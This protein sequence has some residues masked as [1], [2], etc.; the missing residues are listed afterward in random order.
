MDIFDRFYDS[1]ILGCFMSVNEDN[2][3]PNVGRVTG[4][5]LSTWK[6]VFC[7][8]IYEKTEE[9]NPIWL[10]TGKER[11]FEFPPTV[12][13]YIEKN[14]VKFEYEGIKAKFSPKNLIDF[15]L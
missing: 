3:D 6:T 8:E 13:T 5:F 11:K 15:V 10:T 12:M 1:M 4:L 2:K 7:I 9:E 14:I